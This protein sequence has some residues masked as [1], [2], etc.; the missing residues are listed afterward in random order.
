MYHIYEFLLYTTGSKC[1]RLVNQQKIEENITIEHFD[2]VWFNEKR[3]FILCQD[4]QYSRQIS[5]LEEY[6]MFFF[7]DILACSTYLYKLPTSAKVIL[8][9]QDQDE[10]AYEI[11]S[12]AYCL[13]SI[14]AI[15]AVHIDITSTEN[16]YEIPSEYIK[17]G[18][19]LNDKKSTSIICIDSTCSSK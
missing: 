12:A 2:L 7:D 14:K 1:H 16:R 13:C 18:S 6:K 9:V 19:S 4:L 17:M 5:A 11:I 3:Q 10:Y 15:F 8:I